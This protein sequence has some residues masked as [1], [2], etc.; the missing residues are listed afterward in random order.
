[1]K[2]KNNKK[3]RNSGIELTKVIAIF[4]IILSHVVETLIAGS[5]VIPLIRGYDF[6]F[7]SGGIRHVIIML[8]SYA[9][10]L[11]NAIFLWASS[12]FL[13]DDNKVKKDKVF[14]M[15]LNNFIIYF[16]FLV[17]TLLLGYD[18]S[19]KRIHT[20]L[21][22]TIYGLNWFVTAYI[23]LYLI[24]PLLNMIINNINK[25][26]HLC[27]CM[28]LIIIYS[29]IPFFE[30]NL[31]YTTRLT[32][33]ITIYFIT[34]F[35]KKYLNK[36]EDNKKLN[37]T[38]LITSIILFILQGFVLNFL[39]NHFNYYH[40]KVL[41]GSYTTNLINILI[42][43]SMFNVFKKFKFK[44]NIIN[45]ISSLSLL[46]YIIHENHFN[47][48]VYRPI[49]WNHI[50]KLFTY[51]YIVTEILLFGICLFIGSTLLG[52]IYK[53]TIGKLIDK[54]SNKLSKL[55]EYITDK[56][57]KLIDNKLK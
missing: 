26:L 13:V 39:G 31:L 4:L 14:T 11:G 8:C 5:D 1:M 45:Y 48:F 38:I 40:N 2:I 50:Y 56:T 43:M 18:L 7:S 42:A 20:Y 51:K 41:T 9:G 12:Y 37:I 44:S 52:S 55:Y 3:E 25:R 47:I 27:I 19:N 54:L 6:S 21:F 23:M 34:A 46:I 36:F 29:I 53:E 17:I 30:K 49:I 28:F 22:P 32:D 57:Y 16:I 15:I 35:V 24:H 33:L 10:L